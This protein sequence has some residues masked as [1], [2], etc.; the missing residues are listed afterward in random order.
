MQKA[1]R[2]FADGPL[3]L[4]GLKPLFRSLGEGDVRFGDRFGLVRGCRY[5]AFAAAEQSPEPTLLLAVLALGAGEH[6]Q[7]RRRHYQRQHRGEGQAEDDGEQEAEIDVVNPGGA[8]RPEFLAWRWE[9]L[10]ALPDLVVPFKRDVY[11]RVVAAF[12][13]FTTG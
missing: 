8:E 5:A 12:A 1:A 7:H 13:R 9:R 2:E 10:E 6:H 11:R 3:P 4:N